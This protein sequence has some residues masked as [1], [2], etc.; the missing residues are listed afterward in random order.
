VFGVFQTIDPPPFLLHRVCPPPAPKAGG[1]SLAGRWGGGGQYFGRRQQTLDWPLTEQ[2]LYFHNPCTQNYLQLIKIYLYLS[3][4]FIF[5]YIRLIVSGE[6]TRDEE[7]IPAGLTCLLFCGRKN[8]K[9]RGDVAVRIDKLQAL[10]P[11][12]QVRRGGGG[13]LGEQSAGGPKA[14]YSSFLSTL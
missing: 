1:Y 8:G 6:E 11:R 3:V 13:L 12:K 14:L 2:S 9:E 7:G 4:F 10:L 5:L